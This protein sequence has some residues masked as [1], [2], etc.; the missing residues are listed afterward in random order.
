MFIGSAVE[1]NF[2]ECVQAPQINVLG[3]CIFFFNINMNGLFSFT[4]A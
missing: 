4:V 3:C 1:V 2:E